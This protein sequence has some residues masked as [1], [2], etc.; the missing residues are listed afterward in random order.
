LSRQQDD[1][2]V[3]LTTDKPRYVRNVEK[4]AGA[5]NSS[6]CET[7]FHL[8]NILQ[9][10]KK[11]TVSPKPR[12]REE[13]NSLYN[14]NYNRCPDFC[15]HF[16]KKFAGFFE[17]FPFFPR[18]FSVFLGLSGALTPPLRS[19][20][21]LMSYFFCPQIRRAA[22]VSSGGNLQNFGILRRACVNGRTAFGQFKFL[23]ILKL[24]ILR[25]NI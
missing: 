18:F 11:S 13:K 7:V 15:K 14:F 5:R 16:F 20:L 2:P 21:C 6:L 24:R 22:V 4:K 23:S 3:R 1:M 9:L 19:G 12:L 10:Y 17:I 8:K 25:K